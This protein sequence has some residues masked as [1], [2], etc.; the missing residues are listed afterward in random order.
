MNKKKK[1]RAVYY[2]AYR[3]KKQEERY[4]VTDLK[5]LMEIPPLSGAGICCS[6]LQEEMILS[7]P[8]LSH[9]IKD[10]IFNCGDEISL[11]ADILR[12][13]ADYFF[14]DFVV[15]KMDLES[16]GLS[17]LPDN[18]VQSCFITLLGDL[19][20][21]AKR[22]AMQRLDHPPS[23]QPGPDYIDLFT[24]QL[25]YC[26]G[27]NT[28]GI[29]TF[30]SATEETSVWDAEKNGDGSFRFGTSLP[31]DALFRA[32]LKRFFQ[33]GCALCVRIFTDQYSDGLP[34]KELYAFVLAPDFTMQNMDYLS[35]AKAYNTDHRTMKEIK[36]EK[37]VVYCDL[38][39]NK[40]ASFDLE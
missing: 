33:E 6:G 8:K 4:A 5:F 14:R 22:K 7:Y 15:V 37:N 24:T 35:V 19:N 36:P 21:N 27:R 28:N 34:F 12:R 20:R 9:L 26:F 3:P 17:I 29:L 2:I 23:R 39:N 30:S 11:D 31:Q 25:S 16:P 18:A 13:R 40:L 1:R 10:F 38:Q 32:K